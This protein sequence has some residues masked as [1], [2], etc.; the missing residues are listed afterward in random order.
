MNLIYGVDVLMMN[1]RQLCFFKLAKEVGKPWMW[2]DYVDQFGDKCKM[3]DKLY[4]A[5]CAKEVFLSSWQAENL[6]LSSQAWD[7]CIVNSSEASG[8]NSTTT[9]HAMLE[10]DMLAQAG[11]VDEPSVT[12]LP[13]V[14]INGEQYR[15]NMDK[16]GDMLA[17]AGTVDEP[18]VTILPTVRINGEQYRGSMDKAGTVDEPSVTILPTVRINGEQYR[19]NMDKAG[20]MRAI[21]SA[22]TLGQE[23]ALCLEKWVSEDECDAAV[24]GV[25]IKA[26]QVPFNGVKIEHGT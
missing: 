17:Q 2:W 24:N 23:P 5:D 10:E 11:T 7:A 22:F 20:V 21:C 16:A 3:S 18:S 6:T 26:C 15:G 13:T 12:I 1:I 8:P 19:G 14:R 25:G 9:T 4:T